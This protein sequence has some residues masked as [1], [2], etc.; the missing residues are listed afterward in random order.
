MGHYSHIGISQT[1]SPD[2]VILD[3]TEKATDAS[4]RMAILRHKHSKHS[5]DIRVQHN[6]KMLQTKG[7]KPRPSNTTMAKTRVAK[8][9]PSLEFSDVLVEE[10]TE[11][12]NIQC[13]PID[14]E[15]LTGAKPF[16]A[17]KLRKPR[18]TREKK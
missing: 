8:K 15:L 7:N 16:F 6:S 18:S 11:A 5:F 1:F 14:V 9:T 13:P 3:N 12:K 10:L 2:V 17:R 4:S